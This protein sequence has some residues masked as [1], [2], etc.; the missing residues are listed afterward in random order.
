MIRQLRA[1]LLFTS[2]LTFTAV[3]A[4]AAEPLKV[5]TVAAGIYAIVGGLNNRTPENLG[6]N[7]TFGVVVTENG[8]VL[9]DPGGS[10]QGAQQIAQAI[11]S[12]TKQPVVAIINTGGQDHR[13]LGNGYF[14]E[15]GATIIA[16]T[17]A[18]A[19]Q[20]ERASLQ[21]TM[22]A[23]L[24]GEPGL[25]DTEPRYA[26]TTFDDTHKF[27]VGAVNIE[28][29]HRGHAHTPGDSFVW[30]PQT[31]VLFAGDIV[32]TERMLGI[33]SQSASRS[34]VAAFEAMAAFNP[35]VLV[36]GHGRPT[37]LAVAR[38]DTLE[39]LLFVR[40]NVAAFMADG[41]DISD[42]SSVDQSRFRNL[43]NFEL[44]AGRNAQRVFEEL[45]WE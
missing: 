2:F 31:R 28:I 19:D 41:G 16:A 1:L 24:V 43:K 30:L 22:L 14:A 10:Y 18:V 4:A 32:Y 33:G 23:A 8:V 9:I 3:C 29:H 40:K 25:A 13:W 35:K 20:R 6:N 21:L 5:H 12:I 17:A 44:L 42:I 45:E 15:R 11:A 34:W 39:Y 27:S 37:T 36:P 7:A 38:A 26:D